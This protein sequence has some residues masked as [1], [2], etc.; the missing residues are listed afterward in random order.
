MKSDFLQRMCAIR[1]THNAEVS[2]ASCRRPAYFGVHPQLT[3]YLLTLGGKEAVSDNQYEGKG[4]T[5][6]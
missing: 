3:L 6:G 2:G 5:A 1:K 4:I